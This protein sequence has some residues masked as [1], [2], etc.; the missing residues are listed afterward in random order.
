MPERERACAPVSGEVGVSDSAIARMEDELRDAET[1]LA[2]MASV[3]RCAE[4]WAALWETLWPQVAG[5]TASWEEALASLSEAEWIEVARLVGDDDLRDV[6]L[7]PCSPSAGAPR[8]RSRGASSSA[9]R[10]SS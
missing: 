7:P 4:L 6:L 9:S 10:Q 5:R 3:V 1:L 8:I 2:E